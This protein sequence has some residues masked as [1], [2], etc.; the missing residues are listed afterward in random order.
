M[1]ITRNLFP[2]ITGLVGLGVI[3]AAVGI[4]SVLF[5]HQWVLMLGAPLMLP[6]LLVLFTHPRTLFL[7]LLGTRC[8]LDPVLE[9]ARFSSTLGLGA[10][11]NLLVVA[12]ALVWCMQQ[13]DA[14]LRRVFLL[15]AA[16]WVVMALGVAYAPDAMPALKRL[17]A[18]TSYSA[19]F[20]MGYLLSL[21]QRL[22]TLLKV[23]AASSILPLLVGGMQLATGN[24][25]NEGRLASTFTHPNIFAFYCLLV[26]IAVAALPQAMPATQNTQQ[27]GGGKSKAAF[28]LMPLL[29]VSILL[30]QTRSAWAALMIASLMYGILVQRKILIW[31]ALL[32]V[33]AAF[34]PAVQDRMLDLFSG[35]QVVQYAKLNSFAWRQYIWESGLGWMN[36]THYLFGYGIGGF[37]YYSPDFFPLSGGKP[38][39]AHN[40]FVERFFDGGIVAVLVFAIFIGTQFFAAIRL[41]PS[42]KILGL[43]YLTLIVSYLTLN[44]SDN[45]VDYLAYNWYY[46]AV[47]GG[48]FAMA[49]PPAQKPKTLA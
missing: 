27:N 22:H 30:T 42:N 34:T 9:S 8:A 3:G 2:L 26:L 33:I 37:Y 4:Y 16:P 15:W 35:N 45:V 31:M 19:V 47:A 32:V 12:C 46:W 11:L 39:G 7:I 29:A 49:Q 44:F 10:L 24:L 36:P 28:V 41:L 43:V 21:E 6:L 18:F 23:V 40:V 13:S 48:L 25:F 1:V 38:F 17:I 20:V 14:R 5:G